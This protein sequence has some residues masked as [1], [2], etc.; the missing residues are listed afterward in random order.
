MGALRESRRTPE[1]FWVRAAGREFRISSMSKRCYIHR[2][3]GS[4]VCLLADLR[5]ACLEKIYFLLHSG[6]DFAMVYAVK[7]TCS[8]P[9]QIGDGNG[10]LGEVTSPTVSDVTTSNRL[11]PN[12][13]TRPF[14]SIPFIQS[15]CLEIHT[16]RQ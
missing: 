2:L 9:S 16:P 15:G 7:S 10:N 8:L 14:S 5:L 3:T 12:G 4:R 6:L 1:L 11:P 13:V